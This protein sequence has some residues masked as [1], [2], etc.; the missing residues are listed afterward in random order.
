MFKFIDMFNT[1]DR[2]NI[3]KILS[4]DLSLLSKEY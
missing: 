1:Y 2:C 4:L 3:N